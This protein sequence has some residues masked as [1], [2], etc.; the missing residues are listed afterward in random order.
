MAKLDLPYQIINDTP[1]NASPVQADL[2]RIQQHVNAEVIER[3]GTVAMT[4][5]LRL[6]GNPINALDAAPKQYVDSVIPIGGIMLFGG[7]V[8]P[9]GGIWLLCDGS[10]YQ[11]ATYP[12]LFAV[13]GTRFGGSGGFFNTPP[14]TNRLPVGG[15]GTYAFGATGGSAD[16]QVAAH[17]HTISHDHGGAVSG[18]ERQLHR[19]YGPDHLHGVSIWSDYQGGHNHSPSP[20]GENFIT[21]GSGGVGSDIMTGGGGYMFDTLTSTNG[22]HRHAI[23]GATQAADRSLLTSTEDDYHNHDIAV[24][25]FSGNS[26][27]TGTETP[28]GQN[29]PPYV[30]IAFLI[31]AS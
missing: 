6:A 18:T 30:A 14:L 12:D 1:A 19:H 4:G 29:M 5:Q 11:T 13:I 23:N 24:P 21:N 28:T 2:S 9:A 20:P 25:A 31:R 16:L 10:P 27:R 3:G 15:G 17:A 8:A 22:E 26:G 7:V